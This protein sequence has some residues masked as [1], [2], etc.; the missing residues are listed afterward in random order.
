MRMKPTRKFRQSTPA[1]AIDLAAQRRESR[2]DP[3]L[4][5][6]RDQVARKER[7][8]PRGRIKR[9]YQDLARGQADTDCRNSAAEIIRKKSTAGLRT[10]RKP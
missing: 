2:V 1:P 6:E 5:H 10:G 7:A 8:K 4:P 9:A 3:R